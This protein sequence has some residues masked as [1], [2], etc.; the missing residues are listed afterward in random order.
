MI[1][2]SL[3][4]TE[5]VIVFISWIQFNAAIYRDAIIGINNSE[6]CCGNT[7]KENIEYIN[8]SMLSKER[9]SQIQFTW[10]TRKYLIYNICAENLIK[11]VSNTMTILFSAVRSWIYACY[12]RIIFTSFI[13]LSI[14]QTL[15]NISNKF[16]RLWSLQRRANGWRKRRKRTPLENSIY[17]LHWWISVQASYWRI[18][19]SLLCVIF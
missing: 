2:S 12:C 5:K 13:S 1:I 7:G 4:I 9:K 10:R 16:G 15:L 6:L 8:A 14:K 19:A 3:L 17:F 18:M 11:I